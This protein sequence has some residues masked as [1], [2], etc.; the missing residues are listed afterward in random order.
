MTALFLIRSVYFQD[1]LNWLDYLPRWQSG[2]IFVFLFTIISLPGSFGYLILNI[3]AGYMYGFWLGMLIIFISVTTGS[4][5]AF[6]IIRKC[7]AGWIQK[8]LDSGE[9]DDTGSLMAIRR[10]IEGKN[11]VKIIALT[12]LTPLPFGF[13]NAVFALTNISIFKYILATVVGLLPT[14]VLNT[15]FGTTLR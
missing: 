2:L 6:I 15:F 7:L 9:N 10:I 4:I 1:F 8:Y 14:Q 5:L 13:Q 12:R 11:C 3:A